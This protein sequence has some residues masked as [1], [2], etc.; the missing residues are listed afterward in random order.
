MKR[1]F[2]LFLSIL[3][4]ASL[5]INA[6]AAANTPLVK[7]VYP[8]AAAYNDY[9]ARQKTEKDNPV[10]AAF[11]TSVNSFSYASASSILSKQTDNLM[12]SPTSL[13]MA[14]SLAAEGAKG[15]TRSEMLKTLQF[16]GKTTS[17][18]A[19][20]N[21]NLFRLL[22]CDNAAGKL[23][24]ANSVWLQQGMEFRKDYLNT[25]AKQFYASAFSVDFSKKSAGEAMGKWVSDQ[26]NGVLSPDIPI[27]KNQLMA[28]M[29]TVYF[30][31]AWVNHFSKE[32]TKPDFFH[33][34]NGTTVNTDFMHTENAHNAFWKGEGYTAA[35]LGFCNAGN[36]VLI[37]PNQ[38]V[39]VDS[40]LSDPQKVASMIYP[41]GVEYREVHFSVPK[42]SFGSSMKLNDLLQ[43]MGIKAAF[44]DSADFSGM[45]AKKKAKISKV[46]QETHISI[47][48]DG[49][50][51]AAYTK[52]D[53]VDTCAPIVDQSPIEM[54]LD[55]PF[56]LAITSDRQT[57]IPLF[58]G[59]V[60]NPAKK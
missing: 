2:L 38:G 18:L 42:F 55:R 39:S 32:E 41:E 14:L 15:T 47:D 30:K 31:D 58:I 13:Y 22:Y 46:I 16:Q 6:A 50:E 23:K 37:L 59:I 11:L 19:K 26:T 56:L 40:L 43:T 33:L 29:N 5:G 4:I 35:T 48:E 10:D 24:L 51:A 28:I 49:A 7:P 8:K 45:L 17:E 44:T 3:T 60:N 1:F 25:A 21:S 54:K 27:E 12:Y 52:I 34:K 53:M 36:M 20:Q 9:D 57:D